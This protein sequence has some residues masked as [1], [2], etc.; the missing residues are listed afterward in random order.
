M[1]QIAIT[2]RGCSISVALFHAAGAAM[3]LSSAG[4]IGNAPRLRTV[5]LTVDQKP[6]A[7]RWLFIPADLP[8]LRQ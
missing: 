6:Q 4:V 8:N 2:G 5:D 3:S 7:R 1:Q